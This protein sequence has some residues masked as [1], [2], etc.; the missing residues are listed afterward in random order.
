MNTILGRQ[1]HLA[2]HF[3]YLV[4]HVQWQLC[5]LLIGSHGKLQV[6]QH[7]G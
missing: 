4:A 1:T 7:V 2:I 6:L 5:A 3:Q